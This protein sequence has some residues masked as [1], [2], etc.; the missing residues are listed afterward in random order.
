V[1]VFFW[2]QCMYAFPLVEQEVWPQ[3]SADT[4][5]PCPP[6]MTQVQHFVSRIKN[7]QRWDVQMMWAYRWCGST[8][9]VRTRSVKFL[10][11]TVRKIW[12]ILCVCVSRPVTLTFDLLTFK[13]VRNVV[14]AMGCPSA[15][16]GD[17]T[18]T[19]FRLV[20]HWAITAQNDHMTVRP[21]PLTLE[22]MAPVAD[23]GRR[24][25]SV[26]EVWGSYALP[27]GRYGARCVSALMGLVTPI[28]DRLTLKQTGLWGWEHFFRIWAR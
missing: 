22:V 6:L 16:F 5:C 26:H 2:T 1:G 7:R 15:N 20:G 10:G 3:G 28:F 9:S 13:L 27:F 17:T 24:S 14:R 19:R 25:P 18:T 11:L 21:W 4:V 23:A 8:F 12:H